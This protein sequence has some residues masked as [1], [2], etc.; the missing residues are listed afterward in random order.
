M[1][2]VDTNFMLCFFSNFDNLLLVAYLVYANYNLV[3]IANSIFFALKFLKLL[4]CE[5]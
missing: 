2:Y 3:N 1:L 4:N 5:V